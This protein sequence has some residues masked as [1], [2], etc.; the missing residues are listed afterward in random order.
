MLKVV[1][2]EPQFPHHNWILNCYS[3]VILIFMC[4][5]GE[6]PLNVWFL[7]YIKFKPDISDLR[8]V[9]DSRHLRWTRV[10]QV[11]RGRIISAVGT[12]FKVRHF[13]TLRRHPYTR[14]QKKT[15]TILHF[16][17]EKTN[18]LIEYIWYIDQFM[19]KKT[20]Q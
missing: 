4:S 12:A 6:K 10:R 17:S 20:K 11:R 2:F 14:V 18:S 3:V 9:H 15:L 13:W 8:R 1:K 16:E 19:Y 7:L 5:N